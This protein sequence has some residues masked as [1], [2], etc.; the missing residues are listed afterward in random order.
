[1]LQ[2]HDCGS[3]LVCGP[4]TLGLPVF[5]SYSSQHHFAETT[6]WRDLYLM[7]ANAP[8]LRVTKLDRI[9]RM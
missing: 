4:L 2:T 5:F 9:S 6:V 8:E 3:M 1:M 7:F